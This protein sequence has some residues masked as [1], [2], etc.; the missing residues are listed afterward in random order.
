MSSRV[1]ADS[2]KRKVM[3]PVVEPEKETIPPEL[4]CYIC[5]ELVRDAVI[6]PCCAESF[7]DECEY[8]V[9]GLSPMYS[10]TESCSCITGIREYLLENDFTCYLCKEFDVSPESLVPNKSLRAVSIL[11]Q[12]VTTLNKLE[13]CYTSCLSFV[14]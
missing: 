3:A 12:T 8:F 7:C 10:E 13:F 2:S 4:T 1:A 9:F 6:I 5:K 11:N 14:L